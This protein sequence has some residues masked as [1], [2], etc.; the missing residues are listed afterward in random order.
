M[1][2]SQASQTVRRML[3]HE[4]VYAFYYRP[5]NLEDKPQICLQIQ[6]GKCQNRLSTLGGT[7]HN[8]TQE[9]TG[10]GLWL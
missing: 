1:S 5:D 10:Q 2:E 7:F 4:N 8:S 3:C 9:T 6:G